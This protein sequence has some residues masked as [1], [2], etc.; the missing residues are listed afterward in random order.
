MSV[1]QAH[2]ESGQQIKINHWVAISQTAFGGADKFVVTLP[3]QIIRAESARNSANNLY[4]EYYPQCTTTPL[5]Q[6]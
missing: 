6:H 1:G 5:T 2:L 3:S 4:L